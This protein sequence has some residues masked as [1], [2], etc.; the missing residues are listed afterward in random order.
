M[1]SVIPN[2]LGGSPNVSAV[3]DAAPPKLHD[4][5]FTCLQG[6]RPPR[7]SAHESLFILKNF[8]L[9]AL[10]RIFAGKAF[11]AGIV[12]LALTDRHGVLL[13]ALEQIA[14]NGENVTSIIYR[15]D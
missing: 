13:K 15:R 14:V 2:D 11:Y 1:S 4:V 5:A 8:S 3:L 12:T 9:I 10:A 7:Y 6:F